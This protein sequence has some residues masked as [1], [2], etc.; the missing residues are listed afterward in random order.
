LILVLNVGYVSVVYYQD[1]AE[2]TH[3]VGVIYES[4]TEAD[5]ALPVFIQRFRTAA[6]VQFEEAG[7]TYREY[8]EGEL[9]CEEP[10]RL[11]GGAGF[12]C[13]LSAP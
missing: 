5:Q 1:E 6:E 3:D 7:V 4:F 13:P 8:A 9:P 10:I 2:F 11:P 12:Y